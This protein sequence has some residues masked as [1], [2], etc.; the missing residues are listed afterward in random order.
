MLTNFRRRVAEFLPPALSEK[1]LLAQPTKYPQSFT[2][3]SF[4][5][6]DDKQIV[7]NPVTGTFQ[8]GDAHQRRKRAGGARRNHQS[9]R[10]RGVQTHVERG[11]RQRHLRT[12]GSGHA[13][14]SLKG[15]YS[16]KKIVNFDNKFFCVNHNHTI[17]R[18][19]IFVFVFP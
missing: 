7:C 19:W 6:F 8:A 10:T 9:Q 17:L 14:G 3:R 11:S 15:Q 18:H 1:S 16:C 5:Y 4:N 2:F 13:Q 12:Y